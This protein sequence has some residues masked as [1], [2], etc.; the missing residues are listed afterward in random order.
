MDAY[1]SRHERIVDTGSSRGRRGGRETGQVSIGN[2]GRLTL[3]AYES[4]HGHSVDTELMT[5]GF[6]QSGRGRGGGQGT[7]QGSTGNGGRL[8]PDAYESHHERSDDDEDDDDETIGATRRRG[9]VLPDAIPTRENR[10][11]IWVEHDEFNIQGSVSRTISSILQS[12]WSGPWQGWKDVSSYH[13]ERMFERFE[14]Y[15]QWDVEWKP[16]VRSCWEKCLKGKFADVLK[17]ARN[18]AKAL[19]TKEGIDVRNN[20]NAILP[21]KPIW[22][23]QEYWTTL[24]GIWSSDSWKAKSSINSENRNKATGGRHTL[25][26]KS[27]VTVR[28]E[29]DKALKRRATIDEFW[30]QTHVKKGSRPLDRLAAGGGG[31]AEDGLGEADDV[32]ETI[33]DH[34]VNWVDSRAGETIY[35]YK[36]FVGERYVEADILPPELDMDLWIQSSGG[37]K[38]GRLYGTGNTSDPYLVLTG[39]SSI[40]RTEPPGRSEEV[41]RLKEKVAE[42]EREKAEKNDMKEKIEQ[43]TRLYAE[44]N[45]KLQMLSQNMPQNFPPR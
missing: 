9:P 26:S 31:S 10:V 8:T 12:M 3:D 18:N 15:Y 36:E 33:L 16:L 32:D 30:M 6:T 23:G 21:F 22:M 17:R 34:N 20:M 27:F 43:N 4:R 38:K 13:R 45:E 2:G 44:M 5:R 25:G 42:L 24:V 37:M 35:K 41:Q 7:S 1:V 11:K 28:K 29:M 40:P 19:A 39:A 14:N